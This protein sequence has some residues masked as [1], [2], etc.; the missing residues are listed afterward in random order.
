MYWPAPDTN[1]LASTNGRLKTIVVDDLHTQLHAML[2]NI[3]VN[4]VIPCVWSPKGG[5]GP[6]VFLPGEHQDVIATRMDDILDVMRSR[7]WQDNPY[8]TRAFLVP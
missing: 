8:R 3:I 5:K 4:T 6:P 2:Q 7:R 1:S